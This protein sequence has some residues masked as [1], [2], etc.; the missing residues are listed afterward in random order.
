MKK[1]KILTRILL[2][3]VIILLLVPPLSC[4]IFQ[5]FIAQFA[6]R[7]AESEIKKIQ[8]DMLLL[9]DESF[10]N[11][12]EDGVRT[13]LRN[14]SSMIETKGANLELLIFESHMNVIYPRDEE[15]RSK[16]SELAESCSQYLTGASESNLNM[17]EIQ[18]KTRNGDKYLADIYE[19]PKN[20]PQIKYIVVSCSVSRITKWVDSARTL[21]FIISSVLIILDII[22]I[23]IITR[24]ITQ[25][26]YRLCEGAE[27]FGAGGFNEIETSFSLYELEKLRLTMNKMAR[28]MMRSYEVQHDFFQNISHELRNPLMSISGYAQGIE[29]G[30]FLKQEEAAHTILEESTRLTELVNSLLTLSRIESDQDSYHCNIVRIDEPIEECLDRVNGLAIKKGVD[31]SLHPFDENF[32]VYGDEELIC[33]VLENFLTNA[34]R[35]AKTLVIVTVTSDDNKVLVSVSDD[36][37]GISEKDLPHIFERCYKGKNGNFGIGLAIAYSAAQNMKGELRAVN[38][39]NGGAVFTLI[40]NKA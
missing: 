20:L 26:L 1:Q 33:K 37:D 40:L 14:A 13:F 15:A 21:L 39:E 24:S 34:I 23:V 5:Y 31:L 12:S 9:I 2:P 8:Q 30:I 4:L 10:S 28:K 25:P 6:H 19:I 38:Q 3:T 16:V 32:S 18:L 22:I 11:D 7:A 27:R 29:R 17:N 35:Y 36:G